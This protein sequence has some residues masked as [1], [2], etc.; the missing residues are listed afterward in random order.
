M[1][2]Q[3][4]PLDWPTG[5]TRTTWDR[6]GKASF[7]VRRT[8]VRGE[9]ESRRESVV[10]ASLTV[11]DGLKRLEGELRRLGA[12]R[13]TIS[14]NL[15]YTQDGRPFAKQSKILID[16][17]IAVYF[18]LKGRAHVL[19]CDRWQSAADNMAAIAGHIEAIRACDRYG[20]GSIEQAM[21]GYKALPAD[22]AADWRSVFGFPPES[23]PSYADVDAAFKRCAREKHPD[24]I[25]GSDVEMAHLNRARAYALQE[26]HGER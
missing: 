16:P 3:R 18:E 23:D 20:V 8:V 10:F 9:G 5:W 25:G 21:A 19:A 4:Y 7:G 24:A 15:Q 14:S 12:S 11:S 26:V 17:G 13:V 6:R 2:E 1:N 22:T